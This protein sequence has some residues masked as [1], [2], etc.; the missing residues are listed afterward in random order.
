MHL[1]VTCIVA[2]QY[3]NYTYYNYKQKNR[4]LFHYSTKNNT[5]IRVLVPAFRVPYGKT[6]PSY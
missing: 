3:T 1:F 5:I 4:F 6:G 2:M